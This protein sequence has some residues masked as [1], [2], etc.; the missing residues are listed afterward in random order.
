MLIK[1]WT[2]VKKDHC[3]K[4]NLHLVEKLSFSEAVDEAVDHIERY[5]IN[6]FSN[7]P[8][9]M[10]T[11]LKK[12][13]LETRHYFKTGNC[14][15]DG[16]TAASA[17]PTL[18]QP[19]TGKWLVHYAACPFL[20]YLP[21]PVKEME[22]KKDKIGILA[23]YCRAKLKKL[24][25]EFRMR[26]DKVVFYFHPCDALAFCY[27][28]LPYKF[29]II[30][31]SSLADTLGLVNLLNA[32]SRKLLSDESLLI[33]ES[34]VWV[35]VAPTVAQYVQ[36]LLF[37]PLS[38]IPTIYGFRL[39]DSVEWGQ[40]EPRST[41]TT[42]FMPTRLRWKKT[43]SFDQ[44]PLVLTTPLIN[45]L[46]RLM[47][48]CSVNSAIASA[49]P[50]IYKTLSQF[51]SPLTFCYVLSDLIRRGDI[52]EPSTLM[53]TF[54]SKLRPVFRKSFETCRA[55]M[56]NRPVWRVKVRVAFCL[57][58]QMVIDRVMPMGA[59]LLR[60]ILTPT[61]GINAFSLSDCS[62]PSPSTIAKLNDLDSPDNHFIDNVEANL[63]PKPSDLL[64]GLI[65]W[66][67]VA[68]LLEDRSLLD[69]HSGTIVEA[70]G[71]PA[72]SVGPL[73]NSN[74]K[75]ELFNGPYPWPAEQLMN[76]PPAD[77]SSGSRK[78]SQLIG[79]SCRETKNAC[80]I[81]FTI[82][83]GKRSK[84]PSGRDALSCPLFFF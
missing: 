39:L 47:N 28:D 80:T 17:N 63:K 19:T 15:Q 57:F 24:L 7:Q 41:R 48:A 34:T 54:S 73:S 79:E 6:D 29:D 46:Q 74:T 53:D 78:S 14:T 11:N 43:M 71:M 25:T 13:G 81:R 83:P 8:N 12:L 56:E 61:V 10:K 23:D 9:V 4:E 72:F 75:V 55:W 65:E 64:E 22:A 67:D 31:T 45:A 51:F 70:N 76:H 26:M 21:I 20:G 38:L 40:E 58:N 16:S 30:D 2:S 42:T 36:E 69:S 50:K 32:A 59:P 33:T 84:T 77:A 62:F 37:C 27:G 60:L 66:I 35:Y 1:T 68:F 44:V 3:A 5:L 82:L 52:K 49:H 18:L